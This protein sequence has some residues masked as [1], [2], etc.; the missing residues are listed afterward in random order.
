M[1][2]YQGGGAYSGGIPR[3]QPA[4][5]EYICAGEID[6][7]ATDKGKTDM[8]LDYL[9]CASTNEIKPKDPIRCRECGH[10]IMYKKRTNRM[11]SPVLCSSS[12]VDLM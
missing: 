9:E 2:G 4:V 7:R 10:R 8:L 11:V 12:Y 5:M 6:S 1:S 3:A